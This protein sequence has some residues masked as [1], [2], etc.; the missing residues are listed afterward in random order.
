[1][2]FEF[3]TEYRSLKRILRLVRWWTTAMEE[4]E[5]V[6]RDKKAALSLINNTWC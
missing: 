4:G 5:M 2:R 6:E 3:R 1:V